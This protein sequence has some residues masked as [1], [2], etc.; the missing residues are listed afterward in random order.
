MTQSPEYANIYSIIFLEYKIDK[1]CALGEFE[2][3]ERHTFRSSYTL[4]VIFTNLAYR[5]GISAGP[6]LER[7]GSAPPA[8]ESEGPAFA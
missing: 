2:V 8:P 6:A 1:G 5:S 4:P 3:L 7:N